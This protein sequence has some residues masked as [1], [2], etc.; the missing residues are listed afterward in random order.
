MKTKLYHNGCSAVAGLCAAVMLVVVAGCQRDVRLADSKLRDVEV[1]T[2]QQYGLTLDKEASPKQ[3][4]FVLL[5]AMYQDFRA[6]DASA[7]SKALDVQ[8]EVCAADEIVA[9]ARSNLKRKEV[10]YNLVYRWTPTVSYYIDS[11]PTTWDETEKHLTQSRI[12]PAK[13]SASG[14]NMCEVVLPV[15]GAGKSNAV[16]SMLLIQDKGYWRV[17]QVGCIPGKLRST[18]VAANKISKG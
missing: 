12:K 2:V 10:I 11:F 8:F 13:F 18:K 1:K 7:R 15:E 4:A 5:H 3:V 9:A 14:A 6:K 16:V 17:F